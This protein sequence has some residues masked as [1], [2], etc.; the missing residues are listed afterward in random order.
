MLKNLLVWFFM[1][2]KKSLSINE[3]KYAILLQDLGD[4]QVFHLLKESERLN[5]KHITPY[6]IYWQSKKTRTTYGPFVDIY[7]TWWHHTQLLEG[8]IG[9]PF[10]NA[11]IEVDFKNK[12]RK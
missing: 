8:N 1:K 5:E 3:P 2:T 4:F 10:K 11:L 6:E 12:K 9:K 7:S